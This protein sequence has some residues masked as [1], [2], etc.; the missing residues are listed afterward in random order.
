MASFSVKSIARHPPAVVFPSS[1]KIIDA[2]KMMH[3]KSV[4]HAIVSDDGHRLDG[5]VSAKDILNYLGGGEKFRILK[6]L[7][8]GDVYKALH[9]PIEPIV[10]KSPIVARTTDSLP[11]VMSIMAKKDIGMIP[12]LDEQSKIW[13]SLS[14]RHLFKLFEDNQM[15]VKVFEVMS[16]PLITL[17]TKATLLDISRVMISKD[18]R[19]IPIMS[20]GKLWGI[21]T[22]KDIMRFL[23]SSYVE[24][25]IN[26][27]LSEYILNTNVSKIATLNPKIVSPDADL[28]DAVKIMNANNVGSL[29]VVSAGNPVGIVTER[30]LLLKLPRL[31]GVEFM[32]DVAKNRVIV[33]RIHF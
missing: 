17:D 15:F 33:G 22:V 24:D 10:N 8:Q 31:R 23:A 30:D 12:L 19:R 7:Y 20:E 16:K 5:L 21:V 3:E 26:M 27:G 25:A 6:D 14:E 18:I 28:S 2:V 4:R 32:T 13:G 1:T 11:E 9:S 29:I